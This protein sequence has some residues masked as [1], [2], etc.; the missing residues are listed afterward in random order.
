MPPVVK[1]KH[2]YLLVKNAYN[3]NIYS[4]CRSFYADTSNEKRL[5]L[6]FFLLV[7]VIFLNV[8]VHLNIVL[9]PLKLKLVCESVLTDVI[10]L[11]TRIIFSSCPTF[12]YCTS[13]FF[14]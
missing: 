2:I 6:F 12:L 10:L 5:S 14:K 1:R 4:R 11:W 13:S 3:S 8:F 7:M 9:S